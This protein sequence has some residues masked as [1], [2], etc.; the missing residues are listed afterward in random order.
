MALTSHT[1][2]CFTAVDAAAHGSANQAHR[3]SR[4]IRPMKSDLLQLPSIHQGAPG[5][6]HA[7]GHRDD[8]AATAAS[9]ASTGGVLKLI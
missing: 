5:F 9:L 1:G 2:A 7:P 3:D 8:A 6:P 4:L